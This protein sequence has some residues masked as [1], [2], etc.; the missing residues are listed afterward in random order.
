[1]GILKCFFVSGKVLLLFCLLPSTTASLETPGSSFL[2]DNT[3]NDESGG[4]SYK[5]KIIFAGIFG[6]SYFYHL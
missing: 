6:I 2:A 5:V 3:L 4:Y 1:M